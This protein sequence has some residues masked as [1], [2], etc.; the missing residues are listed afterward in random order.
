MANYLCLDCLEF[1]LFSRS[2]SVH[3]NAKGYRN[4]SQ[5]EHT[6]STQKHIGGSKLPPWILAM[7][8][9]WIQGRLWARQV[10]NDP[11]RS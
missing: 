2:A 8:V 10:V 5:K 6:W 4:E 1:L 7:L 11:S 9:A 3:T